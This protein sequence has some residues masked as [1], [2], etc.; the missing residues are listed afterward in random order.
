MAEQPGAKQKRGFMSFYRQ[1]LGLIVIS[2]SALALAGVS[3][4]AIVWATDASRAEMTRLVFAAV[5][6]LI[7]TWVGTVLAYNFS[8][9]NFETASQATKETYAA[10]SGLSTETPVEHVMLPVSRIVTPPPVDDDAACRTLPLKD[11]HKLMTDQNVTRLPIFTTD[12]VVLYVI[13]DADINGYALRHTLATPDF[14]GKTVGDLLADP[15]AAAPATSFETVA[16]SA[17]IGEARTALQGRPECKDVF[18]T[19]GGGRTDKVLGWITNSLL[20]RV[21]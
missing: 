11:L 16:P 7:G 4:V 14:G 15:A 6:P 18:V 5:V 1:W 10:A 12:G 2:V 9:E 3:V 17:T 19:E 20:A 13:H 21:S 8:R